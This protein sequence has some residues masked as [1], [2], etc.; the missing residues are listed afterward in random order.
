MV[1]SNHLKL[2]LAGVDEPLR[3]CRQFA[4]LRLFPVAQLNE[5]QERRLDLLDGI[6]DAAPEPTAAQRPEEALYSVH[7]RARSRREVEDPAE[8]AQGSEQGCS[9]L[10][11]TTARICIPSNFANSI[12]CNYRTK[13]GAGDA[14]Q[15]RPRRSEASRWSWLLHL[16]SNMID[17]SGK[18]F[19]II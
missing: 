11:L 2:S 17:T 14:N 16:G 13:M 3:A 7:S 4:G 9:S 1:C 18:S 5:I 15:S 19:I 12:R 8:D 10:P 6:T